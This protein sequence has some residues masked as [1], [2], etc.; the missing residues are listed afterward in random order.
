GV[1]RRI[2]AG[3]VVDVRV[4]TA[5][6]DQQQRKAR[7]GLLVMDADRSLFKKAHGALCPYAV[8]GLCSRRKECTCR[9]ASGMRSFGCF[10]GNMLTSAFG[11]SIAA[12]MATA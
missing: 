6:R 2:G 12:S 10:H 1:E 3:D 11:A 9:S 8:T 4:Q 5:A 7:A